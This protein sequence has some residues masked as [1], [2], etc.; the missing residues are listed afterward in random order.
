[1]PSAKAT[2]P[3]NDK[4]SQELKSK[5]KVKRTICFRYDR[6]SRYFP[7]MGLEK[8][9]EGLRERSLL[10]SKKTPRSLSEY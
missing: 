4:A 5:K 1:M 6:N 7:R 10:K 2:N 8:M 3:V 9:D